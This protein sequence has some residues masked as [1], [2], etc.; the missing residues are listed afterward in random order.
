M[1]LAQLRTKDI[2]NILKAVPGLVRMPETQRWVDYDS[3][4]DMLYIALQRPQHASDS[5]MRD[6][7]IIIHRRGRNT[8]HLHAEERPFRALQS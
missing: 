1:A 4:A 3:E 5:E 6:D 8:T 7:G 2:T